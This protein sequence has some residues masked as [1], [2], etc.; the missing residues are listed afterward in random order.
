MHKP[1]KQDLVLWF[2]DKLNYKVYTLNKINIAY[3][4]LGLIKESLNMP[5][6]LLFIVFIV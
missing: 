5:Q 4:M 3:I 2:D 6:S 1:V